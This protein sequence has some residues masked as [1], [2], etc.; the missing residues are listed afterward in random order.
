MEKWASKWLEMHS[1]RHRFFF[2]KNVGEVPH[3]P[4]NDKEM[5]NNSKEQGV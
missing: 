3:T 5:Q 1:Q 4:S 2:N